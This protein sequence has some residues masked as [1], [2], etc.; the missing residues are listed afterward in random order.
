ME[1]FTITSKNWLSFAAGFGVTTGTVAAI[2]L[3]GNNTQQSVSV[4]HFQGDK[5]EG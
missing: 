4:A 1:R 5:G 3:D 2:A